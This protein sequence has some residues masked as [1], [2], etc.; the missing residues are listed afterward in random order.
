MSVNIKVTVPVGSPSLVISFHLPFNLT[1]LTPM[2]LY[3]IP[4]LLAFPQGAEGYRLF[5]RLQPQC[6]K[7][8]ARRL[9]SIVELS[10]RKNSARQKPLHSDFPL[11]KANGMDRAELLTFLA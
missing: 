10:D 6:A 11:A 5:P 8:F 3:F 2:R 4:P 9:S 1:P 7:N